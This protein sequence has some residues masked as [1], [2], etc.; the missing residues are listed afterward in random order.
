ST[1]YPDATMVD[2]GGSG[3]SSTGNWTSDTSSTAIK[4][5]L[6][7]APTSNGGATA[8]ATWQVGAG[9]APALAA[10]GYYEVGVFVND[11]HASSSWAPY[12][13]YSA[14]PNHAGV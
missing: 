1:V 6:H 9:L 4:G 11:T 7:W 8:T 2:D 10:D 12:T 13:V 5:S 14:D 3:W